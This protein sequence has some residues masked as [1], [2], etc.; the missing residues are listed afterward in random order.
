[1]IVLLSVV[2]VSMRASMDRPRTYLLMV[3]IDLVSA[4]VVI[5]IAA[6]FI[7][8]QFINRLVAVS[9]WTL[10]ALSILRLL[11]PIVAGLDSIT[12]NLGGLRITPLVILKAAVLMVLL[13]WAAVTASNFLERQL[14]GFADL[15]PSIQVLLSKLVRI[16]LLTVAVII[17]LSSLGI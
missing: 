1:F 7:R 5:N 11:D 15:T 8:N 13:I 4:W 9:V 17:A 14:R 12:L 3:A 10:A 2:R 6:G 16:G